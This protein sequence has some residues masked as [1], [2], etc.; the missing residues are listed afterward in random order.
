LQ[1]TLI[2]GIKKEFDNPKTDT[3]SVL[4]PKSQSLLQL[5][6]GGVYRG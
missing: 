2:L 4:S 3:Q 6:F 5:V 1:S